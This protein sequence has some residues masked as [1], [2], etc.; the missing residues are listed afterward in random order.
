V[1]HLDANVVLRY[2][3]DDDPALFQRAVKVVDGSEDLFIANEVLAEVVYVLQKVYSVE[4][5]VISSRLSALLARKTVYAP[6][7][8]TALEALGL[9]AARNV[10]IVDTLLVAKHRVEGAR[11]F[12]FDDQVNK[13]LNEN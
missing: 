1:I 3:L 4:R 8:K 13:L 12:S 6:H 2:L 10:D 7:K 11:V 5:S 9:F